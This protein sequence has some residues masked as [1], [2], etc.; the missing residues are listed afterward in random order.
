[1][2]FPNREMPD[3]T[4]LTRTRFK[5]SE[6]IV[7]NRIQRPN[8]FLVILTLAIAGCASA[9]NEPPPPPPDRTF[10]YEFPVVDILDGSENL[11]TLGSVRISLAPRQFDIR[12][13][14]QCEYSRAPATLGDLLFGSGSSAPAGVDPATHTVVQEVRYSAPSVYPNRI[15]FVATVTN[16]LERVFRGQGSVVQFAVGGRTVSADAVDYRQFTN[17]IIPPNAELQVSI[18]GPTL[19]SIGSENTMAINIYDIVADT[20]EAGNVT[21]RGNAEWYFTVQREAREQ[22]VQGQRSRVWIPNTQLRSVP[23]DGTLVSCVP[24]P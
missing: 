13:A 1:M 9:S 11:V 8:A 18:G 24:E 14:D 16:Q 4:P 15:A 6:R 3:P 7:M 19:H 22:T 17:A 12:T 5:P 2:E 10:T 21:Q 23:T 20:D